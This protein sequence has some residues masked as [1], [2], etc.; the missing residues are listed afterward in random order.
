M[1]VGSPPLGGPYLVNGGLYEYREP[2]VQSQAANLYRLQYVGVPAT[3]PILGGVVNSNA[4]DLSW[5]T[6]FAGFNL[7][8]CN[9]LPPAGAWQIVAGPYPL[10]NGFFGLSISRTTG[11]QQFFRLRKPLR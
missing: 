1:A 2:L 3:G 9:N 5:P 10:S 6:N 4:L 11:P 8:S 7:E